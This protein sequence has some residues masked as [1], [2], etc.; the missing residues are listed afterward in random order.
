MLCIRKIDVDKVAHVKVFVIV[1]DLII[2]PTLYYV[3]YI[4]VIINLIKK[5]VFNCEY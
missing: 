1:V 5:T 2:V 3:L 4:F